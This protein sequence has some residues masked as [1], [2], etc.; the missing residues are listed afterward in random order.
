M[1]GAAARAGTNSVSR[2]ESE[3][4]RTQRIGLWVAGSIVGLLAVLFVVA[5]IIAQSDWF[6]NYVREKIVS[7]TEESTGGKVDLATFDFDWTHLRATLT[8]FV[9]HGTEPAGSAPLLYAKS[10]T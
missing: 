7:V 8:D 10:V 2:G 4:T 5:I 3:M 9:I 1:A 6:H